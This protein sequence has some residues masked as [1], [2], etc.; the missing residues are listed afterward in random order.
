MTNLYSGKIVWFFTL[1]PDT[2]HSFFFCLLLPHR[3]EMVFANYSIMNRAK[4]FLKVQMGV[5]FSLVTLINTS[6]QKYSCIPWRQSSQF[7]LRCIYSSVKLVS[8]SLW[9]TARTKIISR[10][11]SQ[12]Q[13]KKANESACQCEFNS[14]SLSF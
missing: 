7:L 9:K 4:R 10:S 6:V 12:L 3:T 11:H 2:Q 13:E 14:F 1:L 5:Y 8:A